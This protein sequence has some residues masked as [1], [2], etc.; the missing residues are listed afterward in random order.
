MVTAE[1]MGKF[2]GHYTNIFYLWDNN[3]PLYTL[4]KLS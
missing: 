1:L 3:T 2:F 4:I